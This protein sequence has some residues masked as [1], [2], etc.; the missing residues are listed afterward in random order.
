MSY[1]I[2][3]LAKRFGITTQALRF[4][5][6]HG[7]LNADR[8]MDGGERRY[9]SRNFKWLYSIRRYHD[10]GFGMEEIL[11]LFACR[12][13]KA[14][15]GLVDARR[16]AARDELL[17]AQRRMIAL[18]RQLADLER[19]DRLLR[20]NELELMPDLWLLVNQDD[21]RVDLSP[22]LEQGVQEWMRYLPF[23][24]AASIISPEYFDS[25]EKTVV[26][27]SGFCLEASVAARIGLTP[28]D[29]ARFL[30]SCRAVHTVTELDGQTPTVSRLFS[31]TVG[32]LEERDLRIAG[33]AVGRCLAKTGEIQC[34]D[35]LRPESVYYEFWI[36]VAE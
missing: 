26:H 4:Y 22:R 1:K 34:R 23:V 9:D 5:E 33:P 20:V 14:L 35:T 11:E 27:Q 10:L 25:P 16:M 12:D 6:R 28:G 3:V 7:L 31:R 2:G 36:P 19:I 24:Y 15:R 17:A 13:T 32:F 18:E 21:Q 30:G 29:P 8:F